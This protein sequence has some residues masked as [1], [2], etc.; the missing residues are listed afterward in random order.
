MV[1]NGETYLERSH[2]KRVNI[3]RF[4]RAIDHPK[5]VE[6]PRETFRGHVFNGSWIIVVVYEVSERVCDPKVTE[7]RLAFLGNQDVALGIKNVNMRD[8]SLLL[9]L[10]E[11]WHRAK[12]ITHEDA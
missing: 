5:G 12:Y 8:R 1:H 6:I 9:C 11:R 4:R 2:R 3:A 10:P 7:A